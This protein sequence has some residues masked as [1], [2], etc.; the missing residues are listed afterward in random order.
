MMKKFLFVSLYALLMVSAAT[1]LT[2]QSSRERWKY[3]DYFP[4]N[5]FFDDK[6]DRA[7]NDAAGEVVFYM[8][9]AG[10][11][12]LRDI[13]LD[14]DE[15]LLRLNYIPAFA[16]PL[17]IQVRQKGDQILLT[18]QKGKALRGFVEHDIEMG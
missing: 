8:R 16:H 13:S 2:A 7:L 14:K 3:D 11:T 4:K 15:C 5:Y 10:V 12:P 6:E 17:F 1:S 9:L 18:W